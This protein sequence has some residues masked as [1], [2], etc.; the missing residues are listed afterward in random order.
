LGGATNTYAMLA[1]GTIATDLFHQE[2]LGA[3]IACENE[4]ALAKLAKVFESRNLFVY[5]T[6]DLT[7][8]EYASAFK[9]VISVMAGITSGMGFS[10]GAETHIISRCAYEVERV[11]TGELGGSEETFRM[12]SQCWGN[13][14]WMSC[15]GNTRNREFGILLGRGFSIDEAQQK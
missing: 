11:V 14:L 15:T 8:V 7:G 3:D 2:P 6:T 9:N 1:G 5:P 10:Y 12:N 4:G 13:D